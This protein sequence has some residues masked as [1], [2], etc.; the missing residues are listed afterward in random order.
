M[1]KLLDILRELR[2]RREPQV[3][4]IVN[5]TRGPRTVPVPLRDLR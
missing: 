3:L 5:T 4:V 2:K 1:T